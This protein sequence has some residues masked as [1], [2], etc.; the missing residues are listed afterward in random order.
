MDGAKFLF[1]GKVNDYLG[2]LNTA[3]AYFHEAD[4]E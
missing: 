2:E 4:E 1:G 3:L